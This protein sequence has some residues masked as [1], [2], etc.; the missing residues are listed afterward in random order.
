MKRMIDLTTMNIENYT[1]WKNSIKVRNQKSAR[2]HQ[3]HIE[4]YHFE[5]DKTIHVRRSIHMWVGIYIF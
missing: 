5:L 4:K 1:V 2:N 3:K